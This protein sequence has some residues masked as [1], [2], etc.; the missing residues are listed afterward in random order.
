MDTEAIFI[1]HGE[2][3]AG[4]VKNDTGDVVLPSWFL[5]THSHLPFGM[6]WSLENLTTDILI[7]SVKALAKPPDALAYKPFISILT[8]LAPRLDLWL[9][10][11]QSNAGSFATHAFPFTALQDHFPDLVTG[12]FPDSIVCATTFAPLVDMLSI[13]GCRL[14]LDKLFSGP[15]GANIAYMRTFLARTATCLHPGTY[16]GAKLL[17]ELV[18]NLFYHFKSQGG[19]ST[20]TSPVATKSSLSSRRPTKSYLSKCTPTARLSVAYL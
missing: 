20:G 1:P 2:E 3:L 9:A 4:T 5:P 8:S 18:P 11:A 12:A 13:Y 17:P 15:L 7:A 6:A 14:A 10:A 16:M 19:W